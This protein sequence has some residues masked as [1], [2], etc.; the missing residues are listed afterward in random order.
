MQTFL[1]Y[2]SFA[3][4]AKVLDNKRLGKQ[5]V[6]AYQILNCLRNPNGWKNHPAVKMWKGHEYWLC[7]Y[8]IVI[9]GEWSETRGFKDSLFFKFLAAQ[10]DYSV[11]Q[12]YPNWLVNYNTTEEAKICKTHRANLVKKDPNYYIPKFGNIPWEPYYWPVR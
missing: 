2:S 5:R 4:T 7:C 12:D 10:N 6:E 11:S 3:E 1:P 8:G 9:C